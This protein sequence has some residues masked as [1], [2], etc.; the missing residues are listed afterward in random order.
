MLTGT[1]AL[2]TPPS[3]GR[4][5]HVSTALSLCAAGSKRIMA[6]TPISVTFNSFKNFSF[7]P[8]P[9]NKEYIYGNLGYELM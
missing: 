1:V 8:F 2:R 7:R 9:I 6:Q 3:P 4:G 5:D